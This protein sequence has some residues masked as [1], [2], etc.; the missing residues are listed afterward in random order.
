MACHHRIIHTFTGGEIKANQ[1]L[2]MSRNQYVPHNSWFP[3]KF[4]L[5]TQ[6][7]ISI[8]WSRG[9]Y[10]PPV[11]P[12]PEGRSIFVHANNYKLPAA[13]IDRDW[14]SSIG[15]SYRQGAWTIKRNLIA[16]QLPWGAAHI[17]GIYLKHESECFPAFCWPT[18][19]DFG[20][21]SI[22]LLTMLI[23]K[24]HWERNLL[25]KQN[26]LMTCL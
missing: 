3:D 18:R 8:Q 5:I 23:S 11:E 16:Q 25:C 22:I 21:H 20:V 26:P 17:P 19:D 7:A 2:I 24:G 9:Q 4:M 10:T 1:L 15:L 12:N 14:H 6:G 13:G